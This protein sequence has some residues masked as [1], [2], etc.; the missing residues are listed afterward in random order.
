MARE[1]PTGSGAPTMAG[2]ADTYPATNGRLHNGGAGGGPSELDI[3]AGS[4]FA[5]RIEPVARF[6]ARH[7][8]PSPAVVWNP[9]VA[10]LGD[11]RLEAFSRHCDRLGSPDGL[12]PEE[13]ATVEN[14][15]NFANN[16]MLVELLDWF[17]TDFRYTHHGLTIAESYGRD[18][19][20][21][22]ASDMPYFP[23]VF[24]RGLYRAALF[25][26][27]RVLSVHEPPNGVLVSISRRLIVPAVD[28]SGRVTR[29]AVLNIPQNGLGDLLHAIPGPVIVADGEDRI[30]FVNAAAM[31]LTGMTG[32]TFEKRSVTDLLGPRF[33]LEGPPPVCPAPDDERP[34]QIGDTEISARRW[35]VSA[36]WI[37]YAGQ[38]YRVFSLQEQ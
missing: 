21:R 3:L 22:R 26:R 23:Y 33:A 7:Q 18:L 16:L 29:F 19:N 35:T 9:D 14:F 30:R 2:A 4:L 28:R 15:G 27:E 6:F 36:A 37:I 12:L 8:H 17:G 13:A 25:R 38:P 11:P 5:G 10:A 31:M 34:R 24:F 32:A 1:I 20:G